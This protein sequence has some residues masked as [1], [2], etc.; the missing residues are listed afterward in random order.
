MHRFYSSTIIRV[1]PHYLQDR[2]EIHHIKNVLQCR[3]GDTIAL[4][5][6]EEEVCAEIESITAKEIILNVLS[7]S[8]KDSHDRGDHNL[9]NV[10]N[11]GS[12]H[13]TLACAIPKKGKF[14]TIIEKTT[15]LG[16]DEII[17]IQTQR[18]EII[19]KGE[20]LERKRERFMTV[21]V[22]ASKQ[23][24]RIMIPCIQSVIPFK[25][26]VDSFSQDT[27]ILI[28]S[29]EEGSMNLC[30]AVKRIG[31]KKSVAFFIGP[32]GDFTG[33]EYD[34]ARLKGCQPITLGKNVLRVETAAICVMSFLRQ[35]FLSKE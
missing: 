30:D 31:K 3:K 7:D 29:L 24:G 20:R 9:C 1:N 27:H 23:S 13:F 2:K 18:T 32:E 11:S 8:D 25:S 35:Y 33:D 10:K 17:P 15:E 6:G 4:F 22:N 34:Y 16:I 14:E 12:V 28:A 26:C 5:N 19:L 21:A